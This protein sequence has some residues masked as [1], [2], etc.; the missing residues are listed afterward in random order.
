MAQQNLND[1]L[2]D[3]KLRLAA[4]A[5]FVELYSLL[6]SAYGL[7]LSPLN[8]NRGLSSDQMLTI[9]RANLV[10]LY[11]ALKG[12]GVSS[13]P[14]FLNGGLSQRQLRAVAQADFTELYTLLGG[15]G[16]VAAFIASLIFSDARNS[17]YVVIMGL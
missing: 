2:S 17:Q 16:K 12:Q 9:V 3:E 7:S 1:G 11:A 13:S 10:Q 5:N 8:L 4:A 6:N 14:Q 15:A